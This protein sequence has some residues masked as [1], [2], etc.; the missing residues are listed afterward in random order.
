MMFVI[1]RIIINVFSLQNKSYLI[2]FRGFEDMT[3]QTAHI[4]TPSKSE[5]TSC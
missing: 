3:R 2:W 5:C 1:Q 4:V